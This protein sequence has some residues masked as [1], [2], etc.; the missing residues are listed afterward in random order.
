VIS[1]F[2]GWYLTREKKFSAEYHLADLVSAFFYHRTNLQMSNRPSFPSGWAGITQTVSTL[3]D[4]IV[5]APSS[6]YLATAFLNVLDAAVLPDLLPH[7][8]RALTAWSTAYGVDTS[9]WHDRDIGPRA[10]SWL[11]RI[12]TSHAASANDATL[13]A[14]LSASLDVMVRSGIGE[15]SQVERK[16]L[17]LSGSSG[18][19]K[20]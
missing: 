8:A 6:G 12:L 16:L 7:V 18:E 13:Q 5:T 17:Q 9:F 4:L 2:R 15:A 19:H 3:V 11:D 20:S 14:A 1:R 10:C